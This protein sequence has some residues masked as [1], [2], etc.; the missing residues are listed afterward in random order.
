[1]AIYDRDADAATAVA[2]FL[3]Q[4]KC[5]ANG[6]VRYVSGTDTF[7]VWWL[8]RA[9]Q[10]I[11]WDFAIEDRADEIWKMVD[12]PHTH[13]YVAGQRA[14]LESLD[15]LFGEMAESAAVWTHKKEEL[16]EAGRWAELVY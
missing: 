11:A 9:L 12:D 8:H 6:D 2:A 10:K 13:I 4:F 3:T 5:W 15:D 1:M 7:H 14:I 16:I